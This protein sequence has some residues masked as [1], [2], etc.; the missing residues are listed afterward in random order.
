MA[1]NRTIAV[2]IWMNEEEHKYMLEL[3]DKL[4]ITRRQL[5]CDSIRNVQIIDD[6]YFKQLQRCNMLLS[7]IYKLMSNMANNVNQMARVANKYGYLPQ[8]KSL[9]CLKSQLDDSSKKCDE[10]WE[11]IRQAIPKGVKKNGSTKSCGS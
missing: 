6:K 4:K 8:S 9:E 10:V 11:E 7:E 2:K 3:L 5:I 1:V